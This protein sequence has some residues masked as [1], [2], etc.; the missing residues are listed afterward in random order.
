VLEAR[1]AAWDAAQAGASRKR[2]YEEPEEPATE[3]LPELPEGWCWATVEQLASDEERSVQSG[4]FGSN[5][6]HSEF[7]P[8]GKLV[9]GIDNVQD[10]YFS[11]GRQNRIPLQ[12]YDELVRYKARPGDLVIT[13]MATIG[14]CCVIP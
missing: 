11:P 13:V 6:R 9:V 4:P 10:G 1:R 3:G 2:K 8:T 7:T 5:L 14:R 12:K